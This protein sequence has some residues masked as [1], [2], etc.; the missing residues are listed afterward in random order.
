ML[1]MNAAASS[2]LLFA[3]YLEVCH[4]PY[5]SVRALLPLAF[6]GVR[7]ALWSPGPI[8]G[9]LDQLLF[10]GH[11]ALSLQRPD[12]SRPGGFP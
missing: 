1:T 3:R 8:F 11:R 4:A 2:L 10:T 6:S 7:D 5:L 12:R 9:N